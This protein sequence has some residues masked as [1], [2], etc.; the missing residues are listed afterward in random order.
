MD[1][2]HDACSKSLRASSRLPRALFL[3]AWSLFCAVALNT[4]PGCGSAT[5]GGTSTAMAATVAP[6]VQPTEINV[7]EATAEGINI[8]GVNDGWVCAAASNAARLKFQVICGETTYNYDLPNDGTPT[9]YPINMGDG[10]Y[11]FRIMMNTEGQNYVEVDSAEADVQLSSEFAPFLIP[12]QFCNYN[13]DSKCVEKAQQLVS[14]A[15]NQSDALAAVCMYVVDNTTYD[16]EKAKELAKSS[17][18]IP[19]PDETL[20]TGKGKCFDYASLSAAMLRSMGLPAKVMTGYVGKEQ[21]Y[22][23]WIMVYIDGTWKTA[24]FSVEPNTWSRC[25]VTFASTGATQYSG[26]GSGYTDRY[27]Y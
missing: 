27:T 21:L 4:I 19:D 2:P 6:Y 23:A 5:Q 15:Q 25:D 13:G 24:Q 7:P 22:H 12:N 9:M 26:S 18:Y 17:G 3:F 11:Q 16:K 14:K 1:R 8:D 20:A 10:A